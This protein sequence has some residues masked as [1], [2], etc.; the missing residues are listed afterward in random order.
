MPLYS[1]QGY[2]A[3]PGLVWPCTGFADGFEIP[4]QVAKV[5][6]A[7]RLRLPAA[8]FD[9]DGQHG[10]SP[11]RSVTLVDQR[12]QVPGQLQSR[13]AKGYNV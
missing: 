4:P 3:A 7:Q 2:C 9:Q 12:D 5:G 13:S 11:P 10:I 6:Q 8:G 1:A